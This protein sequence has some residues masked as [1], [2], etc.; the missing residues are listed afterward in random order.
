MSMAQRDENGPLMK[1]TASVKFYALINRLELTSTSTALKHSPPDRQPS[2]QSILK[3]K[4][5]QESGR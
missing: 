4:V 2:T 5:F 1:K 3:L